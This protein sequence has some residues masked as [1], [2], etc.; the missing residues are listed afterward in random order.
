[1]VETESDP[2]HPP[3]FRRCDCILKLDILRNVE[4][5]FRG[6]SKEPPIKESP[7]MGMEDKDVWVTAGEHFLSHLRH[8]AI[9]KPLTWSFKVISDAELTTAWLA[10]I[11]LQGKEILDADAYKVSTEY[12][13]IPDLVVPPDLVV[14]RMGIKMTRN[15]AAPET[16]A[17]ALQIRFHE[18]KPTWIW[19]DPSKP[20][21]AGHLFWSDEVGR[22]LRPWP[23]LEGELSAAPSTKTAAGKK[24]PRKGSVSKRKTLRGGHK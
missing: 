1:M 13:T 8:V 2:T 20:L 6:L 7:L 3:A 5:G 11:A 22:L 18:G 9:R 14:L 24:A 15:E 16:L 17:E 12:I 23:R 4:K 19:D 10:S 21:N